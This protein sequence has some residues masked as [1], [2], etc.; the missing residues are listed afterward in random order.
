MGFNLN[1]YLKFIDEILYLTV[2]FGLIRTYMYVWMTSAEILI[3]KIV[4]MHNY[5]KISAMDE[6]FLTNFVTFFNIVIIFVF[7]MI[8]T[9]LKEHLRTRSYHRNFAEPYEVYQRIDFP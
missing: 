5:S 8:R 7:S 2:E 4:Y 6:Y 3:F 1:N 9:C